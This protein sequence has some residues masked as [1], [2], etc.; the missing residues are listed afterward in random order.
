[1]TTERRYVGTP[2]AAR[3]I[4]VDPKT[5]WRW[6]RAGTATPAL[7]TPGGKPRWD[8]AALRAELGPA[9]PTEEDTVTATITDEQ[10]VAAIITSR[11]GVLLTRRHDGKPP[12]GFL[13][14]E[15]EPEE[16]P[17]DTVAREAKEEAG[18]EVAAGRMLGDRIHPKTGKHMLYIAAVPTT[19]LDVFVGDSEELAEV[20]WVPSLAALYD[21]IP[22]EHIF[23]PV[24]AHLELML[25]ES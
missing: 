13:S 2:T 9:P 14:G 25:P 12:Y 10:V 24:R 21:L 15:V 16:A 11:A 8:I 17:T 23:E 5:L 1:M 4:G 7:V 3:A 18:L 19:S 20:L 22:A 6:W